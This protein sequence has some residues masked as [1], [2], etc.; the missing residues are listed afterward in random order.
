L[1][2]PFR[3]CVD[4]NQS[5]RFGIAASQARITDERIITQIPE[6]N[7]RVA[8]SFPSVWKYSL[9]AILQRKAPHE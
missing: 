7:F 9:S 2:D 8:F 5:N 6:R 1:N 4:E 3:F